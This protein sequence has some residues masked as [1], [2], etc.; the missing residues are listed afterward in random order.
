M[1]LQ[2]VAQV[3]TPVP[4]S[5]EI[6]LLDLAVD[7]EEAVCDFIANALSWS[8]HLGETEEIVGVV[9]RMR[10]RGEGGGEPF[11]CGARICLQHGEQARDFILLGMAWI[12][13]IKGH[14]QQREG[15]PAEL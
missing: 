2:G 1:G 13:W 9:G 6:T 3:D 14:G 7:S 12:L 15:F 4:V 8:R 11:Y 5:E 10:G